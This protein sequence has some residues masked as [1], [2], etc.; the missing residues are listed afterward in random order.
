[1]DLC[2]DKQDEKL[3]DVTEQKIILNKEKGKYF[4]EFIKAYC[5]VKKFQGKV[6]Q[7]VS[8]RTWNL[9]M[10][11]DE[12]NLSKFKHK[13]KHFKVLIRSKVDACE[14]NKVYF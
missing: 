8:Y 13:F 9:H 2:E 1:M 14:V 10:N 5:Y 11:I 7:N 3:S 12:N 4:S 6:H